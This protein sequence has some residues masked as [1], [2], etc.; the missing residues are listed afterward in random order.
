M[1]LVQKQEVFRGRMI[2]INQGLSDKTDKGLVQISLFN[3]ATKEMKGIF[4]G[5]GRR[6]ELALELEAAASA[7]RSPI[8]GSAPQP[9]SEPDLIEDDYD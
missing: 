1:A 8:P 3:G 5:E 7:L 2:R 9:D 6:E 4:I